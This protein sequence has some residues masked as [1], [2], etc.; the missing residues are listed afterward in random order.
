LAVTILGTADVGVQMSSDP[1]EHQ[2]VRQIAFIGRVARLVR[3]LRFKLFSELNAMVHGVVIGLRVLFWAVVLVGF[4]IYCIGLFCRS[5]L[6][7]IPGNDARNDDYRYGFRTLGWSMFT[8]FRCFTDGCSADNGTPLQV[9]L[10]DEFGVPFMV[11]Y[12]FVFLFVTFGIF[13]LIMAI[14]IDYVMLA[15]RRRSQESRGSNALEMQNKLRDFILNMSL[16][17]EGLAPQ[18]PSIRGAYKRL[19]R[20]F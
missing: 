2:N 20:W 11:V 17:T 15:S 5:T 10:A 16:R 9:H 18:K 6:G 7:N 1:S 19:N 8:L 13:N 4:F 14:F 12:V 3:L